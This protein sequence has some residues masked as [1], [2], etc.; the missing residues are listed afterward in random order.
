MSWTSLHL[1]PLCKSVQAAKIRR[2]ENF[3]FLLWHNSG[4]FG[5]RVVT[6]TLI[7]FMNLNLGWGPFF[8]PF[9]KAHIEP[10]GLSA[11]SRQFSVFGSESHVALSQ[12]KSKQWGFHAFWNI[13]SVWLPSFE[14][15]VSH[16]C[17]FRALSPL[18]KEIFLTFWFDLFRDGSIW[19]CWRHPI[20]TGYNISL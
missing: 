20:F 14:S 3:H 12:R 9:F 4:R 11:Q 10:F 19:K 16:V 13:P 2:R 6:L 5:S 18:C 7:T 17:S 1:P 8:S 15:S